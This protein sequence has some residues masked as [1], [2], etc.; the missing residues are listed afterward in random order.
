ME[1]NL[2]REL[3][4]EEFNRSYGATGDEG[5]VKEGRTPPPLCNWFGSSSRLRSWVRS[6]FSLVTTRRLSYRM[7]VF[8]HTSRLD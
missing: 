8:C 4:N 1:E 7:H 5:G 6:I 2:G 3:M